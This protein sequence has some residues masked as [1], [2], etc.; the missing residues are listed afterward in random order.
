MHVV[1]IMIMMIPQLSS[2]VLALGSPAEMISVWMCLERK[3]ALDIP[4]IESAIVLRA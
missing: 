1:D 2:I 4:R 3:T